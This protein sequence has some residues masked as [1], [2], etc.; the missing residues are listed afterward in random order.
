[1]KRE[2]KNNGEYVEIESDFLFEKIED[3]KKSEVAVIKSLR[4]ELSLLEKQNFA[5]KVES[6]FEKYK[7]EIKEMDSSQKSDFIFR[8]ILLA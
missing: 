5:S 7:N 1:M 4:L 6:Y 8:K 3:L 2:I